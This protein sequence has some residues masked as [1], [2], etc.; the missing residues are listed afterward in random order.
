MTQS[1]WPDSI[2]LTTSLACAGVRK[3][4]SVSTRIG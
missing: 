4:L 3:R 1:T 2:P